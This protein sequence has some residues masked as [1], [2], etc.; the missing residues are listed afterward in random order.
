M[1]GTTVQPNENAR[2][3]LASSARW[4]RGFGL[5]SQQIRGGDAKRGEHTE[6]QKIAA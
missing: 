1:T 6:V 3:R 5:K 2:S 4:S